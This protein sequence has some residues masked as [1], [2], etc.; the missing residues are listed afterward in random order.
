M[1]PLKEH[2]RARDCKQPIGA[3]QPM[4]RTT[5]L[6]TIGHEGPCNDLYDSGSEYDLLP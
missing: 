6:P 2:Q 5:S 3:P 4:T 1:L